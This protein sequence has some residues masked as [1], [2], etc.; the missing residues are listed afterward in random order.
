M[1]EI[2]T[3]QNLNQHEKVS[4]FSFDELAKNFEACNKSRWLLEEGKDKLKG[5]NVSCETRTQAEFSKKR[6]VMVDLGLHQVLSLA[7]HH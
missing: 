7:E 1:S 6:S 3:K 5:V 4:R 2:E